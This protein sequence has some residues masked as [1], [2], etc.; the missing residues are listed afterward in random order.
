M[1][2]PKSLEEATRPN[3]EKKLREFVSEGDEIGVTDPAYPRVGFRFRIR[4]K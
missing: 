1:R 2:K 3:L 4:Y